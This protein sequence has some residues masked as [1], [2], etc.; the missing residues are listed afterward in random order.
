MPGV[1]LIQSAQCVQG[2]QDLLIGLL[3]GPLSH[4]LSQSTGA[5]RRWNSRLQV[6]KRLREL[7][8]AERLESLKTH[9][10]FDQFLEEGGD[11][12]ARSCC[13]RVQLFDRCRVQIQGNRHDITLPV[14]LIVGDPITDARMG[15]ASVEEHTV[16]L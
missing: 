4:D 2:G 6:G 7:P 8:L 5:G 14:S 12:S 10:A 15:L 11:F 3:A 13:R 1:A 16:I 9:L